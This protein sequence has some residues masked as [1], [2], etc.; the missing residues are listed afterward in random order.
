MIGVHEPTENRIL[1]ND[2]NH[3]NYSNHDAL[4]GHSNVMNDDGDDER[5]TSCAIILGIGGKAERL[6]DIESAKK[7]GVL[8][9]KRFSG[10]GTVVVDH[11]SLWTTFIGRNEMLPHGVVPYPRE[12]MKWSA[13]AIFGPAFDRWNKEILQ[14]LQIRQLQQPA[15]SHVMHRE[16]SKRQTLVVHGK[17]CGLCGGDNESMALPPNDDIQQTS[18][19]TSTLPTFRLREN[20]YILDSMQGERKI[21][22]NAQA[23]VSGGF[24][25][26]TSFLWDWENINMNYLKLPDKRPLY[27]GDRSHDEFLVRLK[28]HYGTYSSSTKNSLFEHVKFVMEDR[29]HL[30]KANLQDVLMIANEQFGGL[31]QWFDGKCRTR[32]VQ[33]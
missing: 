3:P 11:S 10:G 18:S 2:I 15:N 8:I 25:H 20:D 31:Q 12:I 30:E 26:H 28:D 14:T 23:I 17:S 16:K 1:A 29:F 27:R 9:I 4:F 24:L 7:D 13:D 21:G 19:S 6:I 32:V 5:N 22:G 33:L